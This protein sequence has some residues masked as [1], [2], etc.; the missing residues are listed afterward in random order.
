MTIGCCG[1]KPADRSLNREYRLQGSQRS[2]IASDF[3]LRRVSNSKWKIVRMKSKVRLNYEIKQI[4]F[5]ERI[6]DV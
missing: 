1:S 2:Q 6:N 4:Y 5:I 3:N